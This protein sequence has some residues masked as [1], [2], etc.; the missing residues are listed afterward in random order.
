MNCK[1]GTFPHAADCEPVLDLEFTSSP[2]PRR[3]DFEDPRL[4]AILAERPRRAREPARGKEPMQTTHGYKVLVIRD[5]KVECGEIDIPGP[6]LPNAERIG[7]EVLESIRR[8]EAG[9]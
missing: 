6:N 3:A 9:R 5:D 1:C 8:G 4:A 7:A 2:G